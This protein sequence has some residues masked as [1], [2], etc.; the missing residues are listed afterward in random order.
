MGPL[1]DHGQPMERAA[2]RA[3]GTPDD[4]RQ[5]LR[6]AGKLA[7]VAADER[8]GAVAERGLRVGVDINDDPVSADR[9]RRPGQREHEFAAAAGVR[10]VH[11][12]RQVGQP[13]GDRHRADV[14]GVPR[15]RLEGS[16]TPLMKRDFFE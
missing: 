11:D 16:D 12:D 4:R 10:R 15:G 9:D 5:V 2:A 7:D 1:P 8:L 3:R 6:D 13:L 14:Q